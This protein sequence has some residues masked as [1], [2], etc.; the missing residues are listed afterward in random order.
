METTLREHKW[1]TADN[2]VIPFSE[3]THQHWSNIYWYH[4]IFQKIPRMPVYT[5]RETVE[6]AKKEI[7]VRFKGIILPWKPV[8]DYETI[9]L[10]QLGMIKDG[11][12]IY[13]EEGFKIGEIL[14]VPLRK[15]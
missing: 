11:T 15:A 14:T 9:W 3:M 1:Q 4:L 5:M 13:D 6:L 12:T 2:Q 7:E 8:F 10:L